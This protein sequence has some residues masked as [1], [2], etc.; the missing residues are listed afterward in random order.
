MSTSL[1]TPV[2]ATFESLSSSRN[3]PRP[4]PRSS[5]GAVARKRLSI[6]VGVGGLLFGSSE[7]VL[8]RAHVQPYSV[9]AIERRAFGDGWCEA[10]ATVRDWRDAARHRGARVS[11]ACVSDCCFQVGNSRRCNIRRTH[12]VMPDGSGGCR[13]NSQ[14]VSRGIKIVGRDVRPSAPLGHRRRPIQ[15]VANPG[16]RGVTRW[17]RVAQP[18]VHD[19]W[20]ARFANQRLRRY[21]ERTWTDQSSAKRVGASSS[22]SEPFTS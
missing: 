21:A 5:T 11:R 14:P 7:S 18:R 9:V 19:S 12:P 16:S 6:G 13:V 2:A 1:S 15:L 20:L 8:E 22:S 3:S 10:V 17:I 4:L